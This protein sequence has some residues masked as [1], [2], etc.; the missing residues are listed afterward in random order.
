MREMRHPLKRSLATGRTA[1]AASHRVDLVMS[2][3]I[4]TVTRRRVG[5]VQVAR[6]DTTKW[7]ATSS[8]RRCHGKGRT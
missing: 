5:G 8:L 2:S 3:V 6:A 7:R 4:V 1:A